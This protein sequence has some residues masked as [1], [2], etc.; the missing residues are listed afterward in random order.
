MADFKSLVKEVS[1]Q[2]RQI[3]DSA[4]LVVGTGIKNVFGNFTITPDG[5]RVQISSG[6]ILALES[7][8]GS[9]DFSDGYGSFKT[10]TG[11]ITIGPGN[12]SVSGST[13]FNASGT[14]L[15]V[16]NNT[17]LFGLLTVG[18]LANLDGGISRSSAGSLNIGNSGN[19]NAIN[20]ATTAAT[21][22][23]TIGTA[24]G[25]TSLILGHSDSNVIIGGNL[26][27]SGTT[28]TTNSETVLIND[29][30]IYLN[31][32]Y[33]TVVA[34]TGGI[35]INYFPTSTTT[36]VGG[37]YVSGV[38]A[39]SNPIVNTVGLA[40]FSAG[41]IIQI[42]GSNLNNGLFEVLSHISTILTIRGIGTIATVEDFTDNQFVS[43]V[44][45]SAVI[46]K[47][48]VSLM[49]VGTDGLWETGLGS[50]TPISF[51]D[52]G[53]GTIAGAGVAF[54]IPYWENSADLISSSSFTFDGYALNL[55]GD[56]AL[57]GGSVALE[58][59][60][61]SH[62]TTASGA[63]TITSAAAATWSTGSGDLNIG[64]FSA[65]NLRVAGSSVLGATGTNIT[66]QS[67]LTFDTTGTGT[68]NLPQNT[69]ARF[70]IEGIST[71]AGVS[72]ANLNT[73]TDGSN[74]D[75]LHTHAG[76]SGSAVSGTA[77]DNFTPG[78]VVGITDMGG[79][80]GMFRA[81]ANGT[82]QLMNAIG[83]ATATI[84]SGN[85][86]SVQILGEMSVPDI[87]FDM[88]PGTSDVGRIVYMSANPGK[89]T[90]TAPANPGDTIQKI[91]IVSRGATGAVKV[92]VQIA[93]SVLI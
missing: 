84:S 48:N 27:V 30:H 63:L 51:T 77:G 1:G 44:S 5:Y 31:N 61:A 36:T 46:R 49:R 13:I 45:D 33:N 11:A 40:T 76:G 90:M 93:D 86:M 12:V 25:T 16:N 87:I 38:A 17:S 32:G 92:I 66:I 18:N 70:K 78:M 82:G 21:G 20:I 85:P 57:S 3:P 80:P 8:S 35:V 59:D 29:N 23:I 52:L 81:D 34:Q 56:F 73:L 74:A 47:T 15:T 10:T 65:T 91:G 60:A 24:S 83:L 88:V 72:A 2:V 58:G 9:V 6:K 69:S 50:S 43:S 54:Q 68:I 41:D 67:G 75:A 62:F 4:R 55:V 71:T 19:V 37:A 89:L 7:G 26:V 42:S 28:T 79:T 39:A 14:A 64:G 22:P 53:S